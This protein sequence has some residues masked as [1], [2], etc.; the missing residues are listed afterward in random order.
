MEVGFIFSFVEA[1][2]ECTFL[3]AGLILLFLFDEQFGGEDFAAEVTVIEVGVVDAFIEDLQL[4]DG[5]ARGKQLEED[6][7]QGGFVAELA[8]GDIDHAVMVEDQLGHLLEKKPFG[9]ILCGELAGVLIDVDESEV[10][11]ANGAFDRIAVRFAKG[12]Q[13]FHINAFETGQLFEDPVRGLVGAFIGLEEAAHQAPVPFAGLKSALD[14]QQ[15]DIGPVESE[16][17][18]VDG[19]EQTGLTGV[20]IHVWGG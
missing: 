19:Y 13:L 20:F 3:G 2:E 18:T 12:F 5:E 17:D 11:D 9:M 7:M 1:V 14:E 10:G 4:R 8:F 6:G 15:L 16:D